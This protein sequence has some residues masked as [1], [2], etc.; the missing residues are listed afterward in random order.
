M[1]SLLSKGLAPSRM[2]EGHRCA[3]PLS[4]VL[5]WTRPSNNHSIVRTMAGKIEPLPKFESA[6][7]KSVCRMASVLIQLSRDICPE[8]NE[9]VLQGCWP[10]FLRPDPTRTRGADISC[11]PRRKGILR[12]KLLWAA[13]GYLFDTSRF[14][15]R[16]GDH[17]HFRNSM[18][19]PTLGAVRR[20]AMSAVA[21]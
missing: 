8:A 15:R 21:F 10:I 1:A 3:A 6:K 13:V 12:G 17:S 18:V 19:R 4:A 5:D 7:R 9:S 16:G 11:S 20:P 2:A 14:R